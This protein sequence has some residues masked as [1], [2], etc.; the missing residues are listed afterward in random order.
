MSPILS[1]IVLDDLDRELEKRGHKFARY[2][3]DFVIMVKSQRAGER[4][5]A[6]ITKFLEKKLKL[7]VNQDKSKV[8]KAK[9]C[10]FLGFTFP[11]I[12]TS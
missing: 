8:G 10:E 3:D 4:V 1:N 11:G 12:R 7:K 6:S 5:K 9:K 2:A